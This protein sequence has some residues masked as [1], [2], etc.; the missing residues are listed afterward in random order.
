MLE[1]K[2]HKIEG[3]AACCAFAVATGDDPFE[4]VWGEAGFASTGFSLS[5]GS[6]AGLRVAGVVPD[7]GE[8]SLEVEI[9]QLDLSSLFLVPDD[10]L[11]YGG[12]GHA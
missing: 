10:P 9:R 1:T 6:G 3:Q 4:I 8:A 12:C 5:G 11:P 2:A 7:S